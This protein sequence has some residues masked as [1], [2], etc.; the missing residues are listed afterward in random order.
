MGMDQAIL[1]QPFARKIPEV[2]KVYVRGWDEKTLRAV[3][4]EGGFGHYYDKNGRWKKSVMPYYDPERKEK[5]FTVYRPNKESK[6]KP[7]QFKREEQDF[8]ENLMEYEISGNHPN[9]KPSRAKRVKKQLKEWVEGDR[10]IQ[11][12]D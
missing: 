7:S 2:Q 1:R 11:G 3:D 10:P 4:K 6:P 12:E 9:V 5:R 8:L